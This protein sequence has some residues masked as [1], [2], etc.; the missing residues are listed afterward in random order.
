MDSKNSSIPKDLGRLHA[1]AER[2]TR[3]AVFNNVLLLH[4]NKDERA[5][6]HTILNATPR[7]VSRMARAELKERLK[8]HIL[9]VAQHYTPREIMAIADTTP[10][11]LQTEISLVPEEFTEL[12]HLFNSEL[13]ELRDVPELERLFKHGIK[14]ITPLSHIE[15]DILAEMSYTE[16]RFA[17]DTERMP[18]RMPISERG[19][20]SKRNQELFEPYGRTAELLERAGAKKSRTELPPKEKPHSFVGSYEIRASAMNKGPGRR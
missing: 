20:I 6:L 9:D 10:F 3:D 11:M 16:K 12:C 4:I 15:P 1:I 8:A 7:K 18:Y 2:E 17:K 19:T 13:N 14:E 5:L